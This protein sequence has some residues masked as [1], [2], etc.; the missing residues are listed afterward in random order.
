MQAVWKDNKTKFVKVPAVSINGSETWTPESDV[1]VKGRALNL[2][3]FLMS[4]HE[5]TR[6]EYKEI[7]GSDPSSAAAGAY[8]KNGNE[9]T[10][11]A[12]NNNPVNMVSW[13]D[14]IVYCNKRSEKEGLTPCYKV[15]NSTDS[16]KLRSEDVTCDSTANGYRLPTEAEW[17]WAARGGE[18]YTYAGSDDIN[19]V[20]WWHDNTEGSGTREVK[21]KKANGYG[22]YDM[23]GNVNEWCWDWWTESISSSTPATGGKDTRNHNIRG[24]SW[25]LAYDKEFEVAFHVGSDDP[26]FGRDFTGFRVVRTAE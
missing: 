10:G 11:N 24:G 14:A 16:D 17:E 12:A 7:M 4:D 1:F 25:N 2:K 22:L 9:L 18:N 8:D 5:V 6:G 23:S 21:S 3:A 13:Y 20:A 19:E 15:N 26:D